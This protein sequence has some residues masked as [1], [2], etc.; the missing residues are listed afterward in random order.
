MDRNEM[1]LLLNK[2]VRKFFQYFAHFSFEFNAIRVRLPLVRQDHFDT[3]PSSSFIR[4]L[5][6]WSEQ[7]SLQ[8]GRN[9]AYSIKQETVRSYLQR[10]LD[11]TDCELACN[12]ARGDEDVTPKMLDLDEYGK[13][14]RRPPAPDVIRKQGA[15][16]H[17]KGA[18]GQGTGY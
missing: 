6:P 1:A 12:D 17:E 16:A 5:E 9:F 10:S 18:R 13:P 14:I 11:V 4:V 15:N 7:E 2:L 3:K 8:G